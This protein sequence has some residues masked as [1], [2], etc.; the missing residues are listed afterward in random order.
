MCERGVGRK[1]VWRGGGEECVK[2]L[3]GGS[4]REFC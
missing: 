4:D 1:C 2:V 3:D